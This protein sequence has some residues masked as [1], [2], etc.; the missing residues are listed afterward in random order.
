MK[1]KDALKKI[2]NNIQDSY[3]R[4]DISFMF[5]SGSNGFF[6]IPTIELCKSTKYFE[7]NIWIFYSC[8]ILVF[9]KESYNDY[10]S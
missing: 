5:K 9:S 4:L 10:E 1:I 3:I 7:I 2:K 8:F 6:L